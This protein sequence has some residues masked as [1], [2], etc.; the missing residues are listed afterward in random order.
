[1]EFQKIAVAGGEVEEYHIIL[2]PAKL[3]NLKIS[4]QAVANKISESNF[5]SSTGY[6]NSYNRLYLTLTEATQK[7]KSDLEN[8][9]ITNNQKRLN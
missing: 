4:P 2:D 5:I 9:V 3:S 1:M 8:L 7:N 6:L